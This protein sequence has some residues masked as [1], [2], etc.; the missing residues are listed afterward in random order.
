MLD[1]TKV[2]DSLYDRVTE[3]EKIIKK[4]DKAKKAIQDMPIEKKSIDKD[5]EG[6][7]KILDRSSADVNEVIEYIHLLMQQIEQGDCDTEELDE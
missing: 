5:L 6:V 1:F 4:L 2:D 3:I 7:V